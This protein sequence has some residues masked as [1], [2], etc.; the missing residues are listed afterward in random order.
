MRCG[1][2]VGHAWTMV[3]TMA[4]ANGVDNVDYSSRCNLLKDLYI[5][6]YL[7]SK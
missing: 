4:R 2:R 5:S 6:R 1:L 3:W 7:Y